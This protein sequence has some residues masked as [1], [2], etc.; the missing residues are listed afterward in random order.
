MSAP[1]NT[2]SPLSYPS[3][4]KYQSALAPDTSVQLYSQYLREWYAA[5]TLATASSTAAQI[6]RD[7]IQLLKDLSFLFNQEE[8]DLFL[9]S[10]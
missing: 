7:Y 6:K 4:L 9:R 1:L 10:V 2:N 5:N 8:Q 3:W